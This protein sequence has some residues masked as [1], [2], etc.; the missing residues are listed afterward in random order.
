MLEFKSLLDT[1]GMFAILIVSIFYLSKTIYR[2]LNKEKYNKIDEFSKTCI[3]NPLIKE[4]RE[5][6]LEMLNILKSIEDT[7]NNNNEAL[8]ILKTLK[9]YIMMQTIK[10]GGKNDD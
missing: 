6:Q 5:T 1:Y 10:Y 4:M 8:Y 2:F 7:K 3:Y 9:E